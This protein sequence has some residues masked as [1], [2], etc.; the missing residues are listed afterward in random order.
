MSGWLS[1]S[2]LYVTVGTLGYNLWGKFKN[3][4]YPGMHMTLSFW[5]NTANGVRCLSIEQYNENFSGKNKS[6]K[7]AT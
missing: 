2:D 5:D 7:K 4:F 6:S 1:A 3:R